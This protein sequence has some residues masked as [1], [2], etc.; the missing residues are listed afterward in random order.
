MEIKINSYSSQSS[1]ISSLICFIIGGIFFTNAEAVL[2]I[3][4]IVVAVLL[5]L[6]GLFAL[7]KFYI[8]HKK[9]I[10][11]KRNLVIGILLIIAAAL[12]L[13]FPNLV[14]TLLGLTVGGWILLVGVL[15][16]VSALR[17]EFKTKKFLVNVIISLVLIG[18]GVYTIA[19]GS[20]LLETAGILMMVSSGIE[21]VGYIINSRMDSKNPIVEEDKKEE[22]EV[23]LT[24]PEFD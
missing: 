8:N 1:L 12:F 11:L 10:T 5:S 3:T 16:L 15:R 13:I 20:I 18:L 22:Q 7:V 17:L 4:S 24:L 21:I 14:E 9:G 6:S 23:I 19:S 2:K